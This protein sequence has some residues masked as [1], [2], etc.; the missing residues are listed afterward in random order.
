MTD[1]PASQETPGRA[2][3][4]WLTPDARAAYPMGLLRWTVQFVLAAAFALGLVSVILYRGSPVE[5]RYL[6]HLLYP[7]TGRRRRRAAPER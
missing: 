7:L 4:V 1:S 2:E 6:S 3:F 5:E